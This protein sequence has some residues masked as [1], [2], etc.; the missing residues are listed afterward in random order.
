[1]SWVLIYQCLKKLVQVACRVQIFTKMHL[2]IPVEIKNRVLTLMAN[3]WTGFTCQN[4]GV[5]GLPALISWWLKYFIVTDAECRA[6]WFSRVRT[7]DSQSFLVSLQKHCV[8]DT[9]VCVS[10]PACSLAQ[11]GKQQHCCSAKESWWGQWLHG[12]SSRAFS[13]PDYF[14]HCRWIYFSASANK[15]AVGQYWFLLESINA[16]SLLN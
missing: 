9:A 15:T 4:R 16:L 2:S 7:M 6:T 1:M 11:R 8:C 14:S 3:P 13:C 10:L 5:S 12:L